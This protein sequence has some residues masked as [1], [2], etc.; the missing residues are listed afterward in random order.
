M[1]VTLMKGNMI[2]IEKSDFF[3]AESQQLIEKMSSELASIPGDQGKSNFIIDLA[4]ERGSLWV[5]ARNDKGEAVGCGAIRPVTSKTA[6]LKRMYSDRSLPGIGSALL[7]FLEISS[8]GMGYT[9]M[10]LE[11]RQSNHRAVNFYMK[12]GYKIVS[13]IEPYEG[14]KDILCFLKILL[15]EQ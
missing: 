9:A 7:N 11:T 8:K 13:N 15:H 6:E 3:N 1:M 5:V 12:N 14:Q 4:D 2:T 10:C